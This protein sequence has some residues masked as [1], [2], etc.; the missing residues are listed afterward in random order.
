VPAGLLLVQGTVNGAG[1]DAGV[2]VNGFPALVSGDRWAVEVPVDSTTENLVAT[3]TTMT[4]ESSSASLAVAVSPVLGQPLRVRASQPDGVVPLV[5]TWQV[6]NQT[7]RPLVSYELDPTGAGTFDPP[8]PGLDSV[9]TAYAQPGLVLPTL[10]ATDDH[11]TVYTATTI[12]LAN[13]PAAVTAR[14][15]TLWSGFKARLQ[16]NDVADALAFVAPVLQ[17]RM[18]SVFQQLGADLPSIAAGLG[19][20]HVTD[21]AGNLAEAVVVQVEMR[22]QGLYF[23]HFR[24]D[25]L[26]RW[27]IEEM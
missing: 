9:R 6:I 19:D 2:S 4:G 16:A 25:S 21:Q 23:I 10:R 12:V 26:G 17:A 27:L 7:G 14:F 15:Q 1:A 20:L 22:G 5:V 13:D 18:Q 24:R 11:G 3:V 8:M